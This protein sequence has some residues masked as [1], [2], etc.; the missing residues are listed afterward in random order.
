MKSIDKRRKFLYC[1]SCLLQIGKSRSKPLLNIPC[2]LGKVPEFLHGKSPTNLIR[3]FNSSL[4]DGSV[5]W[6]MFWK[7]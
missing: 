2:D 1:V 6:I 5:R 4:S 3:N 7:F